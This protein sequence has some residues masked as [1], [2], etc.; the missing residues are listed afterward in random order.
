M[1]WQGAGGSGE[2]GDPEEETRTDWG[3]PGAPLPSQP[4]AGVPGQ[5]TAP[6]PSGPPAPPA[7]PASAP[8]PPGPP[9]APIP[10]PAAP[11]PPPAGSGP[12]GAPVAVPT[13]HPLAVPGAPGLIYAGA[14]PRFAAY[15]VDYLLLFLISLPIL[16]ITSGAG[17]LGGAGLAVALVGIVIDAAYFT[18]LWSSSWRATPGM[19]LLKLQIGDAT[20]GGQLSQ[21]QAFRRWLVFGTWIPSLILEPTLSGLASLILLGWLLI[22]LATIAT[23]PTRQGLHDRFAGTAIV[24]PVDGQTSGLFIGCLVIAA[25]VV[26]VFVASIAGL[27]FLGGQ[28]SS[29]LSEVGTSVQP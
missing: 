3:G 9:N 17:T 21:G 14:L 12:W 23:S 29:I 26:L 28:V 6:I 8:P 19:R 4:T 27:I 5:P 25:I 7:G 15:I 24:Q 13:Y 11:A 10:P 18:L 20:T 16:A 22:L 1:V 2:G